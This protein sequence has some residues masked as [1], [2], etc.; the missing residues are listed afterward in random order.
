MI[1][2]PKGGGQF[3]GIGLLESV[4]KVM[5]LIMN[6]RFTANVK[7]HDALHGF[8]AGRGTG[9]ATIEAKLLQQW[10]LLKQI[11]LFGIFLDLRKAHD[12]LDRD[13]ALDILTAYGVGPRCLQL[14]RQFWVQQQVVAKQSGYFGD[15]FDATRGVTQ[16][17][18]ISPTIFNII[19]DAV[20][21]AWLTAVSEV[22][23]DASDGLGQN[24]TSRA[25][26]FC[27][28]D[29]L[30]ASPSK[31]WLQES[32]EVLVDL[33]SRVGLRTNA[34]KTKVMVFLPGSIRTYYSEDAHKRKLE[35]QGDTYRQR[36]RRRVAC[37]ECG[38]DLAAGSIRSHMR[39]QHGLEPQPPGMPPL[40]A[41]VG[42]QVTR[43]Q[44]RGGWHCPVPECGCRG[45]SQNLLSRHF[46]TQ[47]PGDVFRV[48]RETFI[49]PCG[50]CGM[51][52]LPTGWA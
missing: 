9:T 39:S 19:A 1:L 32:F 26:L 17:D 8:R 34:D 20:I 11:P 51:Q 33:F 10:V 47:H 50:R 37:T 23:T 22:D 6:Q 12:T 36:K 21:R 24:I 3:R 13:R 41:P 42:H 46:A 44:R 52:V 31:E 30:V 14:L 40:R 16:G 49:A 48:R 28:D 45:G 43:P 5:S 15:P 18:I 35:G 2:L 38:K 7:F 4:W 29:G 27:A 25:A